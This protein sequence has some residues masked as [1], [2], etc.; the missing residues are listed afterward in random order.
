MLQ[1]GGDA[2][3]LGNE[4]RDLEGALANLRRGERRKPRRERRLVKLADGA[5]LRPD[6]GAAHHLPPHELIGKEGADELRER[7]LAISPHMN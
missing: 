3:L 4:V 5:R 6:A 1:A 7:K 2:I